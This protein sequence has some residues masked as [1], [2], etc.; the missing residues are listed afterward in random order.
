MG[1]RFE[2]SLRHHIALIRPLEV[3]AATA[4]FYLPTA[5]ATVILISTILLLGRVSRWSGA[6]LVAAYA[7][8]AIGGYLIYGAGPAQAG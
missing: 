5:V 7:V 4:R 8:F 6:L 3:D 1:R 2:S